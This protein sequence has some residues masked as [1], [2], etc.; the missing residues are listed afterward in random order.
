MNY[1]TISSFHIICMRIYNNIKIYGNHH[2]NRRSETKDEDNVSQSDLKH[3]PTFLLHFS[4]RNFT[5]KHMLHIGFFSVIHSLDAYC[6]A[7][8]GAEPLT[9]IEPISR[10]FPLSHFV[11]VFKLACLCHGLYSTRG[12]QILDWHR[13]FLALSLSLHST[14]FTFEN[15]FLRA[16]RYQEKLVKRKSNGG[17]GGRELNVV[18]VTIFICQFVYANQ[19][20]I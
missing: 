19:F 18:V 20:L 8:S 9:K 12:W 4:F 16:I 11:L 17:K 3:I 15:Y 1:I 13:V 7:F 10:F 6:Y 5:W 2:N 14:P